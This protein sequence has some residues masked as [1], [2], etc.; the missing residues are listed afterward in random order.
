MDTVRIT[1]PAS[2][3]F[4][5][6]VR[7]VA[8][9]LAAR[10]RFTIDEIEDLKIAVDELVAY[11]TGTQGREGEIEITFHVGDD[12]LEISGVGRFPSATKVPTELSEFSRMILDTVVDDASLVQADGTPAFTLVKSKAS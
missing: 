12:R 10:L 6:V 4:L 9:G 3:Q 2:P 7:L 5:Q 1:I 11:L 8:A